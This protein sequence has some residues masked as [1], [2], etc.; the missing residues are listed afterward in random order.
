MIE[1][2]PFVAAAPVLVPMP[3]ERP[4][5]YAVPAGMRVVPGSIV[6]VPLGPRQVAGIVW[7]GAVEK[8]DA[9]KLRPIEQV[10]DCPPIDRAMRRFVDWIAQYTLSP[11]GMVARMLLRAPEAFDPEPWI[12]GLQRTFAKPDRMTGARMRVLETAEGGL[13][14][15]RSGLAH[16]A[17]VSST[18]IDGLKAQGVFDTVMIPPRPAVA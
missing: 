18:V 12:E 7:D 13:A 5:T 8:V 17:G 2:S 1:D 9:K 11:P 16:A 15:T 4:Y 6:R 3:A 10:F 14:W